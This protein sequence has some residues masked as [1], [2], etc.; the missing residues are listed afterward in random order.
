[1]R[2]IPGKTKVQIELFKGVS[3]W[4]LIIGGVGIAMVLL[5][6]FS[7]LPFKL[8]ISIGV[9]VFTGLLIVRLDT[10]PNYM[11]MLN[12][13]KHLAYSRRYEKVYDDEMIL[14]KSDGSIKDDYLK[15]VREKKET[16]AKPTAEDKAKAKE[17]ALSEKEL[18]KRENEILKSKKAT[19][20]EKDAVWLARAQRSAAKKAER[21]QAKNDSAENADYDFMENIMAF[22]GIKENDEWGRI[23]ASFV[24]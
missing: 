9:F 12:I 15:Q 7:S 21:Q 8:A 22:T 2:L 13:L 16:E 20:E 18:I 19:P 17:K 23:I 4:D 10:E 3:L 11:M 6:L 14:K 5:V 1:M 24:K